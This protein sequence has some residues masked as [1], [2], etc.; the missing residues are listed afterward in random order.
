MTSAPNN[1]EAADPGLTGLTSAT[2]ADTILV[3]LHSSITFDSL[4]S[5]RGP[6]STLGVALASFP[7]SVNGN[8]YYIVIKHRNSLETWSSNPVIF[9][10]SSSYNFSTSSSQAFGD[11]MVDMG[12]GV[13]GIFTGDIN[14]DGEV[15][16]V[17]YTDLDP[18]QLS[19][20]AFGYR[21]TDL[22]GDGEVNSVD[23]VQIDQNQLN[24]VYLLR[25]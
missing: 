14:Q 7:G 13:Y 20:V 16:S 10:S 18:D 8:S 19:G 22:N 12:S 1:A 21:L 24:S 3:Q 23:Y 9:G 17:D 4:F 2:V 15:N 11:N 6:I 25:P 5:W